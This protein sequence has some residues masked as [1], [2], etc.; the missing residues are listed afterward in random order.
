MIVQWLA[1]KGSDGRSLTLYYRHLFVDH[2]PDKGDKMH[3]WPDEDPD[4]GD[5]CQWWVRDRY[6]GSD[7]R[8]HV[9]MADM[10]L[11]PDDATSPMLRNRIAG[12]SISGFPYDSDDIPD[13]DLRRG[14]WKEYGE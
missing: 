3:L 1:I 14:G 2:A 8:L 13:A 5:V 10:Y 9:T 11:R 6:W 12:G 4:N 7:G